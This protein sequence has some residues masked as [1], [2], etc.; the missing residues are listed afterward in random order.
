VPLVELTTTGDVTYI[1]DSNGFVAFH[2]PALM[3]GQ[4]FLP[5]QKH[6]YEYPKDGFGYRGTKLNVIEGGRPRSKFIASTSRAALSDYRRRDLSRFG[7]AGRKNPD[8][9]P[10]DQ[11]AGERAG[12]GDGDSVSQQD[13]LVLGDTNR[14]SYPLGQFATSGATSEMTGNGGLDPGLGIDLTYFTD[15]TG[16]SRPM[17]A[18][19]EP[20]VKW[21]TG[22]MTVPDE[23]G[24]EKLVARMT[25]GRAWPNGMN[26]G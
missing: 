26:M 10:A 4:V 17:I 15:K 14:P 20:G 21:L 12:F 7:A 22:I 13:L 16:F 3:G 1:T 19:D 8:Q 5:R 18:I 9:E 6:G 2:D 23:N 25:G 24:K 11:W